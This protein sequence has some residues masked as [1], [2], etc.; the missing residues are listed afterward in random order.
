MD[1]RF[2]NISRWYFRTFN[3]HRSNCVFTVWYFP[4]FNHHR[5]NRLFTVFS[6]V[7]FFLPSINQLLLPHSSV[8]NLQ[9]LISHPRIHCNNELLL[10]ARTLLYVSLSRTTNQLC[11]RTAPHDSITARNQDAFVNC[12]AYITMRFPLI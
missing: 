9:Y 3:H 4:T 5:S 6:A 11:S 1:N 7:A 10:H 12:P 8:L 2:S